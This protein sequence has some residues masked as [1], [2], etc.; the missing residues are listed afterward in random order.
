MNR[1]GSLFKPLMW[2]MAVLLAAFVAGCGGGS[3]GGGAPPK[4][5]P[6]GLV[7]GAWAIT[8][9]VTTADNPVCESPPGNNG[10]DSY[11]LTVTQTGNDLTVARGADPAVQGS[12]SGDQMT[13]SG[14]SYSELGGTTTVNSASATVAAG[15]DSIAGSFN[16]S[17]VQATLSCSGTTTFT[18][19]GDGSGC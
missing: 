14:A 5:A 17:H 11:N 15:C 13:W 12:I 2:F 8:E 4:A 16:W 19:I 7:D 18:G 10:L 6:I 3:D 1:F 9:V